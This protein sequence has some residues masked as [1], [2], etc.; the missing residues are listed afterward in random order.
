MIEAMDAEIGRVLV[1]TGI[2]TRR[3][4]GRLQYDPT[5]PTR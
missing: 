4:D 2:A 3:T 5:T 1:E